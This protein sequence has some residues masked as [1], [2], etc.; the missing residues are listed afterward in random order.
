MDRLLVA[1]KNPKAISICAL[2]GGGSMTFGMLYEL[3]LELEE[4]LVR[5]VDFVTNPPEHM[6]PAFRKSIEKDEV[7]LYEVLWQAEALVCS[8]VI[9]KSVFCRILPDLESL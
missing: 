5:K 9:S 7:R 6:R 3:T 4:A 1:S 8:G 2:L